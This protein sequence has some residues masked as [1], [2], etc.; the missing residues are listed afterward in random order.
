MILG[1]LIS[2]LAQQAEK[3]NVRLVNDG[4]DSIY[5]MPIIHYHIL[6]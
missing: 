3:Q 2:R 1:I 4:F 5:D 6:I